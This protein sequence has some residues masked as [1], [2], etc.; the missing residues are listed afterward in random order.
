MKNS[1]KGTLDQFDDITLTCIYILPVVDLHYLSCLLL[2]LQTTLRA[3][4][5]PPDVIA[6]ALNKILKDSGDKASSKCT[7]WRTQEITV[8]LGWYIGRSGGG[9]AEQRHVPG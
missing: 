6:A 7:F 5:V 9:L 4:G 3:K 8:S 1:S 2:L